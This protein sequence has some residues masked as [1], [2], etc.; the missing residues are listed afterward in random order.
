[1]ISK[2]GEYL[3]IFYKIE[4]SDFIAEDALWLNKNEQ[5]STKYNIKS[6]SC[7]VLHNFVVLRNKIPI[8]Y[9][10]KCSELYD[11]LKDTWNKKGINI[12]RFFKRFL[13]FTYSV[14]WR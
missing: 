8:Y 3:I 11:L 13:L 6:V 4:P 2:K 7:F 14:F 1:M 5:K 12:S 9:M 10:Y